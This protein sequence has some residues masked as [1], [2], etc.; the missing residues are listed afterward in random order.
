[1]PLT[2]SKPNL[3]IQQIFQDLSKVSDESWGRYAMSRELLKDKLTTDQVTTLITESE[4]AGK[5]AAEDILEQYPNLSVSEIIEELGIEFKYMPDEIIGGRVMFALFTSPNLIQV[6]HEPIEKVASYELPE[7]PKEKVQDLIL[8]HEL[9]HYVE[10][11]DPEIFTQKTEITLWKFGFFSQK[12]TVRTTSEI[13]A[14]A[15]SQTLNQLSF[16]PFVMDTLLIHAY[17]VKDAQNMYQ[18]I[19]SFT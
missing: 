2:S 10:T 17:N 19:M 13:A 9:F 7:L 3:D 4:A 12:S 1:M 5:K 8:A 18:E 15:F 11:H 16:S 14:M 6:A